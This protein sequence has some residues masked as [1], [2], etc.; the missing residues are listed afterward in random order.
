MQ[1]WRKSRLQF[2]PK[3]SYRL[4]RPHHIKPNIRRHQKLQISRIMKDL[5]HSG[6]SVEPNADRRII[7][8][9]SAA[10]RLW[11]KFQQT[12][13]LPCELSSVSSHNWFLLHMLEKGHGCLGMY[14]T[15]NIT[16]DKKV[17]IWSDFILK[18]SE[19][20]YGEVLGD[21]SAMYIRVT[22]YWGY[23][24]ILWLFHLGTSCTVFVLTCTVVVL[25]CFVMCGCV[26]VW[27]FWYYVYLYLLCFVLFVL[28]FL[29]CLVYVYL[30]LFALSVLV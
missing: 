24:I 29:Y 11:V 19:V 21:K 6:I 28:C 27:V 3:T 1:A 8:S 16:S 17:Q 15:K 20:S 10:R 4:T 2:P 7:W 30:F 18:R 5:K 13:E 12:S 26:Y 23:L 22:L 14:S 9:A 25:T